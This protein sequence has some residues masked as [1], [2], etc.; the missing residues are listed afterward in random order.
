MVIA[1]IFESGNGYVDDTTGFR[2]GS[3]SPPS[4]PSN[5]NPGNNATNVSVNVDPSWTCTDPDHDVLN[6]DIYFGESSP[7]PLV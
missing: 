3:N 7:P 4:T 2:V 6:Y 5:P 1:A